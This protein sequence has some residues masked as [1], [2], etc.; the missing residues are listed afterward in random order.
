MI[1]MYHM[2]V[3]YY[4]ILRLAGKLMQNIIGLLFSIAKFRDD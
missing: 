1:A 4:K 3:M 2:N